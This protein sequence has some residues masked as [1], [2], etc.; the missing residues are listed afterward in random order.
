MTEIFLPL[1]MTRRHLIVYRLRISVSRAGI[2]HDEVRP[3]SCPPPVRIGQRRDG[4]LCGH[5]TGERLHHLKPL[6]TEHRLLVDGHD[7]YHAVQCTFDLG[8][9]RTVGTM[10]RHQ[11]VQ[12]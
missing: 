8:Q 3:R 2:L 11:R 7:A 4:T 1:S 9:T 10:R 6:H 5:C 12:K